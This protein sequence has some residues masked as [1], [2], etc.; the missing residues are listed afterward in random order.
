MV[1]IPF[2]QSTCWGN[3]LRKVSGRLAFSCIP[4]MV[5]ILT[6]QLTGGLPGCGILHW[7]SLPLKAGKDCSRV[8]AVGLMEN[9]VLLWFLHLF[10]DFPFRETLGSLRRF[11]SP[12]CCRKSIISLM[13]ASLPFSHF[14]PF[15]IYIKDTWPPG[16]IYASLFFALWDGI[17]F[18]FQTL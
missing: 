1:L 17:N 16:L 12:H 18:I 10:D 6:P 3:F 15:R 9:R 5:F 13:I 4:A 7:K 2:G 8:F 11:M 14:S